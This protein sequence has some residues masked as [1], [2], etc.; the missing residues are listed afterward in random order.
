MYLQN[1]PQNSCDKSLCVKFKIFYVYVGLL[2]INKNIEDVAGILLQYVVLHS[3]TVG[4]FVYINVIGFVLGNGFDFKRHGN[5]KSQYT[6]R[7]KWAF[8]KR[9]KNWYI[10]QL[11]HRLNC[12]Y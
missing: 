9:I 6:S 12:K 3:T 1:T 7:I 11:V 5:F 8:C 2:P 10:R 4:F